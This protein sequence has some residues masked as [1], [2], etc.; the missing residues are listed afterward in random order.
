[1]LTLMKKV[2]DKSGNLT[3]DHKCEV[4]LEPPTKGAPPQTITSTTTYSIADCF[5]IL[6]YGFFTCC[7][8]RWWVY[9]INPKRLQEKV[10]QTIFQSIQ[11]DYEKK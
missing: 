5:F 11:K 1:M 9:K 6:Q 8:V 4:Q 7:S 10:N 2:V 3:V